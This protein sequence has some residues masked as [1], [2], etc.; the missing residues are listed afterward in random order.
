[1]GRMEEGRFPHITMFSSLHGDMKKKVGR[2]RHTWEKCV[3]ADLMVLGEDEGTW[4]ASCQIKSAWRKRLWD[5][6]PPWESRR[7]VRRRRRTKQ[8]IDKH[9]ERHVVPFR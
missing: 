7:I 1:M 8:A 9:V 4:E 6:T 2:T 5:L 3:C